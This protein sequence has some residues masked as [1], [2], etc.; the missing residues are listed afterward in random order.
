MKMKTIS[1][2]V[3]ALALMTSCVSKKVY[4]DLETKYA[5]LKKENRTLADENA[6]LGKERNELDNKSKDL[7]AQLDK[8][9][10]ERDK[11]SKDYAS[12]KSGLDKMQSSYNDLEKSSGEANA[13]MSKKNRELLAE[14]EAKQ[15][16]LAAEQA[17]LNMLKDELNERSQRV[18][19]LESMIAAQEAGLKKLK[20]TLS[21]ALNGFEGK[22]LTVEQKNGK[23]YV[24]MENKLLFGSGSWTVGTEGKKAVT[25]VAKVLAA[26]PDITVLIEGHTDNAAYKGGGDIADNW[27]LSTK[28]ATAIVHILKENKG[29]DPKN[30]TAAGRSEYA[31]IAGNDTAEGKSKNRRI[32]II[33]TPKL[34]ELNKM[35]NEI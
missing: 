31:P 9:I 30:L 19:E 28:R 12:T 20:E 22:G 24:S 29:V 7:Q 23:V 33:L 1:A 17:R 6:A 3:L 10:A 18:D 5:D 32:E 26:N 35:L 21:K 4:T 11:L 13:S 34:D 27:D 25:E 8:L 16:A 2:A 14:L 15:K